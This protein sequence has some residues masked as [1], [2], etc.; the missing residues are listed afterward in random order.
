MPRVPTCSGG[1]PGQ[2]L[3]DRL[4]G[5]QLGDLRRGR[6]YARA[7]FLRLENLEEAFRELLKFGTDAE[8][9]EPPELRARI[10]ETAN[11]VAGLY[12]VQTV[13]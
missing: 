4:D 8:V 6:G 1:R 7:Q 12:A 2:T 3:A 9:L 11:Q 13:R 10:A 5:V